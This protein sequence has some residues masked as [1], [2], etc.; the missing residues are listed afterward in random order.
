MNKKRILTTIIGLPIIIFI[1]VL[2][3]P[4][5]ISILMAIMQDW[6]YHMASKR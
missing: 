6:K 2:N 1:M 4:I 5:L 3:K